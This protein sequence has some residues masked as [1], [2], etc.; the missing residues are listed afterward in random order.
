MD[1]EQISKEE[2]INWKDSKVTKFFQDRLSELREDRKEFMAA[3][4]TLSKDSPVTTDFLVGYIQGLNEF[5]NSEY[6]ERDQYDH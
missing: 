3:G 6:E 4:G 2:F 5:L 1:Q